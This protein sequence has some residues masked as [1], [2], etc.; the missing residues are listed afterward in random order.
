MF[1]LNKNILF[2]LIIASISYL[3]VSVNIL[4]LQEKIGSVNGSNLFFFRVMRI[5]QQI[6]AIFIPL[7]IVL[8]ISG[9]SYITS[10]ILEQ[11]I[12]FITLFKCISIAIIPVILG[13]FI[14]SYLVLNAIDQEIFTEGTS[15][16]I[17]LKSDL[18]YKMRYIDF[19]SWS[20]LYIVS[21]Y[22]L[23]RTSCISLF[24]SFLISFFP[25]LLIYGIN[26]FI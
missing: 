2:V 15:S 5:T 4:D 19:T 12:Q 9:T 23:K 24:D 11:N 13:N 22:F 16:D 18:F 21:I 8:G 17:L 20:C 1:L 14:K 25:S 6:T 26:A 7:I 3:C 10:K